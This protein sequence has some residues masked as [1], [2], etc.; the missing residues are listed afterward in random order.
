MQR[1][2]EITGRRR[3][4]IAGVWL[5][6]L[7]AATPFSLQQTKH[8]TGGG[9]IAP[10]SGSDMVE[11][12]LTRFPQV[13]PNESILLVSEN[14]STSALRVATMRAQGAVA[15]LGGARQP[16]SPRIVGRL[17]A[18]LVEAIPL[19]LAGDQD[20]R[21]DTVT[22]L[23][24]QIGPDTST[25]GVRTYLVGEDA[26][27]AALHKLT[28]QQLTAAERIGLPITL[29]ILLAVFG[30]AAAAALPLLLAA[31]SVTITGAAIFFLSQGLA[32][33]QFVTNAASMIGIGVAIDYSLFIIARYR[34]SIAAGEGEETARATALR[35]SGLAVTVSGLTVVISLGG[36]F[37]VNSITIRSMALGMMIVVAI[38]VLG[39]VTLVPA[40]ISVFGRHV[41][42]EGRLRRLARRLRLVNRERLAT[43][44]RP[45]FW[46]RWTSRVMR[47][48]ILSVVAASAAMLILAVPTL[49]ITLG[50]SAIAQFPSSDSS[51]VAS[52]VA[53]R[54]LGPGTATPIQE[55]ATFSQGTL[56]TP[57]NRRALD[58]YVATLRRQPEI[59][60]VP[61]A[62]ATADGRSVALAMISTAPA[63]TA[64]ARTQLQRLRTL[65][66]RG[67]G[68]PRVATVKI[69]GA[70]A[71][72][73]D[74]VSLIASSMWKIALFIMILSYV[75][76]F[77]MLRSVLLPVKAV[78]MTLLSVASAYGV[79]VAVF[80]WG[81]LYGLFGGSAPGY[82]EST[83][84][85]LLLAVVFGLS[86]DYE[87][88]MLSR[89]REEY[90]AS[91]DNRSAVA[92]GLRTSAATITS[93]AA[94][95]VS[96]FCAFAIVSVPSVK[97]LGFGL[98]VAIALDA[99]VVRL[100]LVPAT[101]ELLGRWNWWLP[102]A[103]ATRMPG[104]DAAQLSASPSARLR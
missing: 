32:M 88:F 78:L 95:M 53:A 41:Y 91:G 89:I 73:E 66:F 27:W 5:V 13:T 26:L 15:R 79:L 63:D 82:I 23:R 44:N 25:G 62:T 84:P 86:M 30:A 90:A 39:T 69:G 10:G 59:A 8:L 45:D 51:Y 87:V 72:T 103:L 92:G 60:R 49:Q 43:S 21:I 42:A 102:S 54:F 76:L 3:K 98:A 71:L 70:T 48:P 36:L 65:A 22:K 34:Q 67:P 85:P 83:T 2:S 96:V 100:V 61:T 11:R 77:V 94:I 40:L 7:L 75:V 99:T 68:L 1:L 80:K 55:V 64:P 101:M 52:E 9:F 18:G 37:L 31:V 50:E 17:A 4:W 93:A 14:H 6:L 12:A 56:R 33:S 16:A 97:Q 46:T 74:F 57:V 29:V 20:R 104:L 35:T 24:S 47:R 28:T 81:W 58:D 19:T 38:S